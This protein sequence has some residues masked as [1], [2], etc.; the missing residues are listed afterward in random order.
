MTK[1]GVNHFFLLHQ[2]FREAD[3]AEEIPTT[4][5]YHTLGVL[6]L[7]QVANHYF[8]VVWSVAL[9][10]HQRVI[11]NPVLRE[12]AADLCRSHFFPLIVLLLSFPQFAAEE[13]DGRDAT[14][15]IKVHAHCSK[16]LI[17]AKM[18]ALYQTLLI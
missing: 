10:G 1:E 15:R 14:L 9:V 11:L 7:R 17:G 3:E 12:R 2:S 5:T 6:F 18:Q 8:V 4:Q 13:V 16:L